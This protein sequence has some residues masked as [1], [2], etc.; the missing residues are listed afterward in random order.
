MRRWLALSLILSLV[1]VPAALA[2]QQWKPEVKFIKFAVATAGG[3]WFRA[4]AKY[5]TLVPEAVP[6]LAASTLMG[7]GVV[8]V[9]KVGKGEA[10]IGFALTPYPEEGYQGKGK[11]KEPLKN[12]RLAAAKLGRTIVVALVVLKDSPIQTIH[13][14]KGKRIVTGDRGWGTTVLAEAMMAAAGMPPDKFRADGGT[15]SYTS[16]TDRAK[17]LQDRNIDA[18]FIPAQVNYPDVMVVQQAL[19]LRIIPMPDE[20]IETTL[21]TVP[22]AGRGLVPKGLYGVLDKDLP[23]PGFLQQLIVDASLSD[24]LVYRLTK[25][26]WE[27]IDEIMEIAPTFKESNVKL[28]ME[29]ATIPFHPGA[30]RYYKEVGVAR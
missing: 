22:G 24:E 14:L 25:L 30:V 1:V 19:G 12:V 5:T 9:S 10:Q 4:G 28:A 6:G 18:F 27:R 2:Q 20:V 21:A 13:D 26:W 29:G 8:N 15:I 3:D 11:F 7:G 23:S 17:A 16:I